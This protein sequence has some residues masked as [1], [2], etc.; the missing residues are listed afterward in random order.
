MAVV[1]AVETGRAVVRAAN[2]G[3]SG[4]IAPNGRIEH[5]TALFETTTFV[6]AIPLRHAQTIYTRYG[7]VLLLCCA[8]L[9]GF[10]WI[11]RYQ[12]TSHG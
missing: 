1:R 2:T 3:I 11:K 5:T 12:N 6:H 8:L 4:A 7:N 9:L 10:Y